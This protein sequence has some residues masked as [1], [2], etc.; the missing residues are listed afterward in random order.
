MELGGD[1]KVT[2]QPSLGYSP[3][4]L[5]Q[6]WGHPAPSPPSLLFFHRPPHDKAENF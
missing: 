1:V 5:S 4:L 6:A 2:H 3:G